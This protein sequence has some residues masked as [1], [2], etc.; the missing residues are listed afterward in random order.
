[1]V[2]KIKS[3]L[4]PVI[5]L[6]WLTCQ[7]LPYHLSLTLILAPLRLEEYH[8]SYHPF[9]HLISV[10]R[11]PLVA[12]GL[13]HLPPFHPQSILGPKL[14]S[15]LTLHL[16]SVLPRPLVAQCLYHLPPFP[17]QSIPGPRPKLLSNLTLLWA[18]HALIVSLL[19][20]VAELVKNASTMRDL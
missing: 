5:R 13:Y 10:L 1:M 2:Q 15:N 8:L 20:V 3:D 4:L 14:L 7:Q 19:P 9:F 16:I 12:P 6:L 18:Q 17:Q 11:R